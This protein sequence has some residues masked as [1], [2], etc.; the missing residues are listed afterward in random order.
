[1]IFYYFTLF[2]SLSTFFILNTNSNPNVK[3]NPYP[4]PLPLG[5]KSLNLEAALEELGLGLCVSDRGLSLGRG[6]GGN[7][8]DVKGNRGR[9]GREGREVSGEGRRE[10]RGETSYEGLQASV[11]AAKEDMTA[12]ATG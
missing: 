4:N 2:F 1:M 8:S 12:F 9:E 3:A 7:G 10:Y 6:E 5:G 11:L